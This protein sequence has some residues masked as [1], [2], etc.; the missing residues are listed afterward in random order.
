MATTTRLCA[1]HDAIRRKLE[2]LEVELEVRPESLQLLRATCHSLR[3]LVD[4]HL[5]AEEPLVDWV[6]QS[7]APAQREQLNTDHVVAQQLLR[8]LDDLLTVRAKVPTSL[9]LELCD[10]LIMTLRRHLEME[11]REVFPMNDRV[12]VAPAASPSWG[13][14]TEVAT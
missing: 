6:D 12:G 5:R 9:L 3:Q 8:D 13:P 7:L 10:R 1:H 4:D 14:S 2:A 11:E